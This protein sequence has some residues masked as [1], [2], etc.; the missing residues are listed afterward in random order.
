MAYR[1]KDPREIFAMD[2]ATRDDALGITNS[3]V[4]DE[5]I[6]TLVYASQELVAEQNASRFYILDMVAHVAN[7]YKQFA[8]LATKEWSMLKKVISQFKS[9]VYTSSDTR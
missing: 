7:S 6:N 4:F 1:Y 2:M 5:H 9:D 8:G 3:G